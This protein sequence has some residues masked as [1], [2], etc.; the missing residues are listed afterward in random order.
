MALG[1]LTLALA[2]GPAPF[3]VHVLY[4]GE[5]EVQSGSAVLYQGVQIGRVSSVVLR[6]DNSARRA[7][8]EVSL[9]ID[10]SS[11]VL[12]E[13]DQF[14]LSHLRGVATI[15]VSASPQQARPLA[16]GVRVEGVPLLVSQIEETLE[17]AIESLG[18]LAL[19]AIEKAFAELE[20]GQLPF[21]RS[22]PND[23]HGAPPPRE[24]GCTLL[25]R[26]RA[27]SA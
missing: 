9:E 15:E 19:E 16:S 22:A 27:L 5:V 14:H 12:R 4:P 23:P 13:G 18:D 25:S 26:G 17:T 10:D 24:H 8:V 7:W 3:V 20:S 11:V 2:C 1:A 6:Q 21:G